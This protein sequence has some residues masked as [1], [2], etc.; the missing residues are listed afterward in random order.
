MNNK[1]L[2]L[3]DRNS[4]RDNAIVRKTDITIKVAGTDTVLFRGCNKVIIPGSYYTAAKH[5]GINP[6][7][8]LPS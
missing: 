3:Y 4:N 6:P 2:T 8:K 5:F 7:V 1:N